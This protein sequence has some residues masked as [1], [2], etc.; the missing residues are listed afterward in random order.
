MGILSSPRKE[1]QYHYIKKKWIVKE[2]F[3]KVLIFG[4]VPK[5][6][7]IMRCI[8]L[9]NFSLTLSFFSYKYLNKTFKVDQMNLFQV[10]SIYE[11]NFY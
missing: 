2:N 11:E 6:L 3:K 4:H 5:L 10:L 1:N 8:Y 7:D 9:L